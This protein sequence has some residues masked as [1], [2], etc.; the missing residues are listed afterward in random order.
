MKRLL[1]RL[2]ALC[3]VVVLGLI[4]ITLAQQSLEGPAIAAP[5]AAA[6][7]AA[8]FK[9]KS[10]PAAKST[11]PSRPAS[12]PAPA[13]PFAARLS[14]PETPTEPQTTD[15]SAA[16]ARAWG[17]PAADAAAPA[18]ATAGDT[19]AAFDPAQFQNARPLPAA[20][21]PWP[22]Q[23]AA[24]AGALPAIQSPAIRSTEAVQSIPTL[25]PA[26][27]TADAPPARAAALEASGG[28]PAIGP[29][30]ASPVT[31]DRASP[32]PFQ[33][34]FGDGASAQAATAS[35]GGTRPSLNARPHAEG[36][37]RPGDSQL[38]GP[39]TPS[40]MLR[41]LAPDE[42]QVG[43]PAVFEIVVRNTG[44]VTAQ[45]VEVRDEVPKGTQ[46]IGTKPPANRSEAGELMWD[47]G[48]LKPGEETTL[49]IELLPISEGEI[50]SV[51][52]VRF[53]SDASVKTHAT[54]P[55]LT[56]TVTAP[57]QVLI[58]QRMALRIRVSNPGT[59]V[60]SGVVLEEHVPEGLTHEAGAEIEYEIGNLN[61]NETRELDLELKAVKP[62]AAMNMLVV[63][64]DG[65][66]IAEDRREVEIVAPALE[67][68]L[69]GAK[70]RFLDRPATYTVS[71]S[72]PGTA[73]AKEIELVTYLPKGL[74]FVSANNSGQYD[75]QTGAVYWLLEE[76]PP[77]Q[78]GSV[79]LT[80]LAIEAGE[81]VLRIE[82]TAQQGVSVKQ[83]QPILVEG[84]AAILF[85]LADVNDPIEVGSDTSY[86]IHVINQGSKAASNVQLAAE[87]PGELKF[88][89]ADGPTRF[90]VEG[91]RVV[92]E[93]LPSLAPKADTTY[94]VKVQGH[95]PGDLR[96]RVLL[97]T[98]EM[99]T[100][101][102][103]EE[104]TQVFAAE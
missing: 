8:R 24:S 19:P 85:Q 14:S 53:S 88:Q 47:L 34:P 93:S 13:N 22:Q 95:A 98:D 26:A 29:E 39:Q 32:S 55:E 10:A 36:S 56:V 97:M 91:Q 43:K 37:G 80:T 20:G 1:I 70:R 51:A 92:F 58:G 41:K 35:G 28:E 60:A 83:E 52:S 79:T 77:Q 73:P 42:I 101:V 74:E 64:G 99:R 59:G 89:S 25:Q 46:L 62:G 9:S 54:R 87:L 72:N 31:A 100:P 86:E 71:V 78:T 27:A 102:T 15:S 63:R 61:P 96:V 68:A 90:R 38:E 84:V 33:D 23:P 21:N 67:V 48:T 76:L 103:K 11:T 94:R 18:T 5:D 50:G 7:P 40:L 44:S 81:Q 104:S 69:N 17:I 2:S 6:P 57:P 16:P 12:E 3:G 49:E 82:G 66:L 75:P 65:N 30:S 45:G 4:A